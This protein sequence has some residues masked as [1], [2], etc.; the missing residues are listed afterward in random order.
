MNIEIDKD[1]QIRQLKEE[2]Q[3][4]KEHLKR[5]T[6]PACTKAYYQKNKEILKERNRKYRERTNYKNKSKP[7]PEQ[8]K[9]YNKKAYQ[10]RKEKEK[11]Q[12]AENNENI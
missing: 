11:E 9:E 3:S 5:Y 4:T 10:K 8:K 6:A 2:L 1:E 12:L 7:T